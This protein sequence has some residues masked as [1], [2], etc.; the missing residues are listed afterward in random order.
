MTSTSK[1]VRLEALVL[2]Q[3]HD[4]DVPATIMAAEVY[5]RYIEEGWTNEGGDDGPTEKEK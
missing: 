1:Q 3:K 5:R 4:L 2:A